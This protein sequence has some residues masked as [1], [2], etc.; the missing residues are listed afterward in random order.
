MQTSTIASNRCLGVASVGELRGFLQPAVFPEIR[1][2]KTSFCTLTLKL[3]EL[4]PNGGPAGL[5]LPIVSAPLTRREQHAESL[6]LPPY[7]VLWILQQFWNHWIT[8]TAFHLTV[9]YEPSPSYISYNTYRQ[10]PPD[11]VG[12]FRPRRLQVPEHNA[13]CA[14]NLRI[15]SFS[16]S[17]ISTPHFPIMHR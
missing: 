2:L 4:D 13:F 6:F 11:S 14:Q 8:G 7:A 1:R 16:L 10:G 9:L 3:G 12:A 17:A 15:A 5:S